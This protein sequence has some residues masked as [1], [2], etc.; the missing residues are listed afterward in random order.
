MLTQINKITQ[1][2]IHYLGELQQPVITDYELYARVFNLL[3]NDKFRDI[4]F[5]KKIGPKLFVK[6]LKE[7]IIQPII[8]LGIITP[9]SYFS[10]QRVFQII[11]KRQDA[12]DIAC[13]VDP[14]AYISHLSAM[15]YHGLTNR[16]PKVIYLTSLANTDWMESANKKMKSD[17]GNCYPDYCDY[18][19]PRLTKIK[20]SMIQNNK[21][22]RYSSIHHGAFKHIEDRML[23]VS[24]IGRTFLDMLREPDYCGSMYHVTDVFKN[25]GEQYS[26]LIID[27]IDRHGTN[28]EKSRAGYLLDEILN[29]KDS[30]IDEW[31]K[32]V[33]RGGSRKLDPKQPYSEKY[34]PRWSISLNMD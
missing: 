6:R 20:F 34:S 22:F 8:D 4:S 23:R 5:G 17:L 3:H 11:S 9:L 25:F 14:F 30:K 31:A 28:I 1:T 12:E 18:Y 15:A 21:I 33:Q 26:R 10:G 7:N 24:T 2:L 13:T 29:I 16:L 19:F 27:E 32:K